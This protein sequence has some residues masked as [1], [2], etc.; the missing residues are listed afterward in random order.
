MSN[1]HYDDECLINQYANSLFQN[2]E[3]EV[4]L[5]FKNN[6]DF[7]I[8]SKKLNSKLLS[9]NIRFKS[10]STLNNLSQDIYFVLD[11]NEKYPEA[12]PVLKCLS[13]VTKF[14]IYI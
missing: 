10:S 14:I 5:S 13:N 1:I 12:K 7:S 4:N 8:N 11:I 2:I 6:E 9:I 3:K